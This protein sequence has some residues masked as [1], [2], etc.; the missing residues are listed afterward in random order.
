M[1]DTHAHADTRPSEDFEQMALAGMTDV[2]TLAHD[3]M[4]MSSSVVFKDHFERLFDERARAGKSGVRLHVC[5]GL[6]PRTRPG[7]LPAC[8]ALLESYLADNNRP[9]TAIGEIGLETGNA[10][11]VDMLQ[12]QIELGIKYKLPVIIHTPRTG[13]MQMTR[14]IISILST[15][16]LDRDSVVI[17][18]ADA[19]TVKLIVD[20]GFNAGLTIQPGKLTPAQAVEI[21]KKYDPARLVLNTD[22]SSNPTDVLGVA[23]AAH[24]MRLAGI[25]NVIVEA[26]STKNAWRIFRLKI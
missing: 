8:L 23:R 3:P 2:L 15:F 10:F 25:Y 24:A 11:E 21:V 26:V 12:R 6:H 19:D 18:H 22:M 20:R 5:L 1:I 7:D 16:S 9:V 13:K 4:K 17:D 14:E